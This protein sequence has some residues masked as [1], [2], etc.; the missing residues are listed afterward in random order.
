MTFDREAGVYEALRQEL[1][2]FTPLPVAENR[3]KGVS[4][5]GGSTAV[6]PGAFV[7]LTRAATQSISITGDLIEWDAAGV[8]GSA[9]FNESVPTTTVTI[10]KDGYYNIGV[11]F[12]WSSFTE[13]GT[14]TALRN[15]V[16]VWPPADGPNLWSSTG[17]TEFE[18]VAHSI[19]CVAGDTISVN[20]NPDDASAQTMTSATLAVYLV[21]R[22]VSTTTFYR[23]LVMSHGPVGYWRLDEA[24]GTNAADETG[25]NDGT[26]VGT[27]VFS[28]QGVMQD[29]SGSTSVEFDGS[30]ERVTVPQAAVDGLTDLSVEAWIDK[31]ASA[32]Y[33]IFN[34]NDSGGVSYNTWGLWVIATDVLNWHDGAVVTQYESTGTLSNNT[35]HYV[36]A[37]RSSGGTLKFYIDGSLDS[38]HTGIDVSASSAGDTVQIGMD[39][40]AGPVNNDFFDGHIDEVA[41]YDRVLTA[42]EIQ[43]H[44]LKGL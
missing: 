25:N 43:Q 22:A 13:G 28:A 9:E 37:T 3:R 21:D 41:L 1:R 4:A 20:L 31:D 10:P 11:E 18:G 6:V 26:Y 16:T 30:T 15:G 34:V 17:G 8:N 14:V 44:Y 36:A 27:P 12:V 7:H 29:G 19:A 38:T 33:G 32:R 2:K 40:D 42:T 5:I 39:I 35:R 23:E 24:S